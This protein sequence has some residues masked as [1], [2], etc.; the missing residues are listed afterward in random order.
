MSTVIKNVRIIDGDGNVIEN[1]FIEFDEKGIIAVSEEILSGS[2]E[3]DGTGKTVMPGLI[4]C[5]VHLAMMDVMNGFAVIE[6]DN[7]TMTGV[8]AAAQCQDYLKFGITTIRNMGTKFDSDIYLRNLIDA[9]IAKGPRIIASGQIIAITGGHGHGIALE[10]DTVDQA[11]TSARKQIKK[12]A[13]MIKLM[14]TGGVLTQGSEVGA[15]QLSFEQ[16]KAVADEAKRTGR[17]TG[18][19][20]I[21]Y[22]GTK[23]AILAGLDSIEHGYMVDGPLIEL[24]HEHGTYLCPTIIAS[25]AIALS[26]DP[27]PTAVALRKKI[28]P[29]A[30]GHLVALEKAVK[31]GVKIAAGTDCGTPWNPVSRMSDELHYY[32]EAGMTNMEALISATKTGSELFVYGNL[33]MQ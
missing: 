28:A 3:I 4:D 22:E 33:K 17:I 5:H 2:A 26:D 8:K 20:C 29:I 14:A 32:I 21:G 12:G 24:M 23:A 1:G 6:A 7:E 13:Q 16:M 18:A 9:G 10:S 31:S 25:R 11:L 19:H 15:Q 27:H 30:D